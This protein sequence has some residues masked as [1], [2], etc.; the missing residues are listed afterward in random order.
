MKSPTFADSNSA[1]VRVPA[2]PKA[3]RLRKL[4]KAMKAMK[5]SVKALG[6]PS[7]S[8]DETLSY[9]PY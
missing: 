3:A 4:A 9:G 5:K 1:L 7:L 6:N 8:S 2:F